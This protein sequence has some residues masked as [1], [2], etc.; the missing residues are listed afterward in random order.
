MINWQCVDR[1]DLNCRR[2]C[3]PRN[4]IAVVVVKSC[5]GGNRTRMGRWIL[6]LI[7]CRS[8]GRVGL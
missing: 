7:A 1:S 2:E 4:G 6:N 5:G 3:P 8:L